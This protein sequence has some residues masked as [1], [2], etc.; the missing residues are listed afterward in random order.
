MINH[1]TVRGLFHKMN[2]Y[3]EVYIMIICWATISERI[4]QVMRKTKNKPVIELH[5]SDKTNIFV[6]Q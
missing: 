1:V 5:L 2:A 4:T 3:Y 6:L